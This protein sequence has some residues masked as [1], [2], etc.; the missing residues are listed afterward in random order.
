M[1]SPPDRPLKLGELLAETVRLYG[2]RIWAAFGLGAFIAATILLGLFT[3]HVAAYLAVVSVAFTA[4][5][6]AAARLV[7]GD[8]FGEAWAQVAVRFPTLLVLTLVVSLPFEIGRVDPIIL[9][10]TVAW[11][12][13]TGFSIPITVLEREAAPGGWFAQLGYA[14][15]RSIALAR[16]EYFHAAGVVAALVLV[17]V[18]VGNLLTGALVGFGESGRLTASLLVQVVLAPF[19]FLGLSVL[20]FEQRARASSTRG[21]TPSSAPL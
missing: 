2:E 6:A 15:Q 18:L 14:L 12:A 20:F 7:S 4:A 11:V 21:S 19:F 16:A 5:Y 8:R 13:A 3:G 10:F 17:Y 1:S 9:L